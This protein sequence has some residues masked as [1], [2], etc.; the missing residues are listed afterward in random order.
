MKN[1]EN[2]STV[3]FIS[4]RLF[5]LVFRAL[6]SVLAAMVVILVL[7]TWAILGLVNSSPEYLEPL[8]VYMLESHYETR[9]SWEGVES[10]YT[11]NPSP[12]I[13]SYQRRWQD[14]I[15]LDTSG[16]VVVDQG[17][18]DSDLVGQVYAARDGEFSFPI[19]VGGQ[20]VGRLVFLNRRFFEPLMVFTPVIGP[21]ALMAALLGV[22]ALIIGLLLVRRVVA[23]LAQVIAAARA[24]AAG[25]LSARVKVEGPSDLRA[26]SDSFNQM[27]ESLE[28]ND[29]ERREMLAIIA[30]ELRTPLSVLRGRLEGMLDG[31]YTADEQ[32]I[33]GALEETYLLERLVED[34]R[35]LT[36]AEAR[37]LPFDRRPVAVN[38]LA[39]RV[40]DLFCAEA[41]EKRIR[42]DVRTPPDTVT[43][44]AD[45]QRLE[46]AVGNLLS[47][48]LRYVE[49]GGRV[50]LVVESIENRVEIRVSDNG[51]GVAEADLPHLFE[52]FWR[53]ESARARA[54]G[55]SGLGLAIARELVTAQG[56]TISARNLAAGGLEIR[57]T[58]PVG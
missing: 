3:K 31:I 49:E 36:L 54:S 52:R 9:G 16:R 44:Q 14:T 11:R 26:L 50:E 24:V 17:S 29:R 47:N 5:L 43:L 28:R 25:N 45:G 58:F 38:D 10:V 12:M 46:Q 23:P 32:H 33:A 53:A 2:H 51:P 41:E 22:L 35:L 4:R 21:F 18:T 7:A 37:Q 15:L 27:A 8:L 30:H 40:T 20:E 55:G 42:L 57:I 48:A 6:A 13:A 56:G 19:R 1:S 34:L 39:R